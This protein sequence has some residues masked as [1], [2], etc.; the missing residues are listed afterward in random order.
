MDLVGVAPLVG[1]YPWN[2]A[3]QMARRTCPLNMR[4]VMDGGFLHI[5]LLF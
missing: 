3:R 4:A 2:P 5:I 1:G